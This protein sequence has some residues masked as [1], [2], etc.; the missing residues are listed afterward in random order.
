M[1]DEFS[2]KLGYRDLSN[3]FL[4][5]LT[6]PDGLEFLRPIVDLYGNVPGSK[7]DPY[8]IYGGIPFPC[9]L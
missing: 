3:V 6:T 5:N 2:S 9:S 7:I 4:D 8:L 1:A